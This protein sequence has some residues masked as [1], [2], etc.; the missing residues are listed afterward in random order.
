[1]KTPARNLRKPAKKVVSTSRTKVTKK[2]PRRATKQR[3]DWVT[4]MYDFGAP[5]VADYSHRHNVVVAP[6]PDTV[7][8]GKLKYLPREFD[9]HGY[10]H[11]R[12]DIRAYKTKVGDHVRVGG[13]SQE[14]IRFFG[15]YG[16]PIINRSFD[17][18]EIDRLNVYYEYPSSR[19]RGGTMGTTDNWISDTGIKHSII[20]INPRYIKDEPTI[21]H[22]TIHAMRFRDGIEGKDVDEDEA[23]TELETV[24]RVSRKGLFQ[25]RHAL[26]YYS[27]MTNGFEKMKED[28]ILLTGSL[29]RSLTGETARRR[30]LEVFPRTHLA[31]LKIGQ[32]S[33]RKKKKRM[34]ESRIDE[35]APEWLDRYFKIVLKTGSVVNRHMRFKKPVP[36]ASIVGKMK[37]RYGS[38]L[39]QVFEY[40]DG[41][42]KLVYRASGRPRKLATPTT[43]TTA[44]KRVATSRPKK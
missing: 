10:D 35:V 5:G 24:A 15:G 25:M 8:G 34:V 16:V 14:K 42:K 11:P 44:K 3:E 4:T 6:S 21:L 31:R 41:V 18:G 13:E 36:L 32:I 23:L 22:E 1:M 29:D 28:R 2:P 7:S 43:K 9:V 40:D 33:D 12:K 39:Y 19:V 30:V 27:W 26:G 38:D 20:D 17:E 37:A